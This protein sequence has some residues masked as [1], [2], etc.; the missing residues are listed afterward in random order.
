M[1][2]HI[3]LQDDGDLLTI[4]HAPNDIAENGSVLNAGIT[5]QNKDNNMSTNEEVGIAKNL[6]KC[7]KDSVLT[8]VA[9]KSPST[10]SITLN[11]GGRITGTLQAGSQDD[12]NVQENWA[13]FTPEEEWI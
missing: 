7:K 4:H 8:S 1:A 6:Q 10:Q 13:T 5:S 3:L 11:A 9:S 2:D 12:V